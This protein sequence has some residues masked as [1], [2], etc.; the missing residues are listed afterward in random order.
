MCWSPTSSFFVG[1]RRRDGRAGLPKCE[2]GPRKED[3]CRG[4]RR[5]L[6]G[7]PPNG[8]HEGEPGGDPEESEPVVQKSLSSQKPTGFGPEPG[9]PPRR[10]WPR[11]GRGLV[12]NVS[13]SFE[14]GS[15]L[16]IGCMAHS[17]VRQKFTT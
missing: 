6:V 9:E 1:G 14:F 17:F 15:A 10:T 3:G 5:P 2:G 4:G 11:A 7:R 16:Q 8:P 12:G 13:P